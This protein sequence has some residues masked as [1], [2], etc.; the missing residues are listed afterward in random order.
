M[1]GKNKVSGIKQIKQASPFS[2][3]KYLVMIVLLIFQNPVPAAGSNIQNDEGTRREI[4]GNN[5]G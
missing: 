3:G 5:Y 4:W 1:N 2:N